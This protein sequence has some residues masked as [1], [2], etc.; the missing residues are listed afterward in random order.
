M[1][2]NAT[3]LAGTLVLLTILIGCF[4]LVGFDKLDGKDVLALV[5]GPVIGAV[6]GVVGTLRGV[7]AG[8]QA[9]ADPPPD[10]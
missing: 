8:S 2:S 6:V 5:V 10:A 1:K 3:V 7:H 9:T 4:I